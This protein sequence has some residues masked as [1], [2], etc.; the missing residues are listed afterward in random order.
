MTKYISLEEVEEI[1]QR[2]IDSQL[3]DSFK[4]LL[5]KVRKIIKKLPTIESPKD[6]TLKVIDEMIDSMRDGHHINAHDDWKVFD[7]AD[8]LKKRL[9]PLTQK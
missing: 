7:F 2:S 6:R 5:K 8:E 9:Y 3:W 1:L 4:L